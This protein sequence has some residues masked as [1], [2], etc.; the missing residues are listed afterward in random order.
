M[1]DE[2]V[3]RSATLEAPLSLAW[4]G[5]MREDAADRERALEKFLAGIERR[6]FRIA[7]M[8]LRDRAETEDAVQDA[9]I[10]LVRN[11]ARNPEDRWRPLFYR[12][13]R[14]RWQRMTPEQRRRVIERRRG[15]Q[16]APRVRLPPG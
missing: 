6:A 8:A 16:P 12:I 4:P 13:L 3:N 7:C 9:M 15:P 14:N 10:R 11:Y 5:E 2:P 1:E